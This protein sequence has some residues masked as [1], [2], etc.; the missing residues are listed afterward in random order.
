MQPITDDDVADARRGLPRGFHAIYEGLAPVVLG[1]LTGRRVEDPE[2][3]TQEVLLTLFRRLPEFVGGSEELRAFAFTIAHARVVDHIRRATRSGEQVPY[4][5]GQDPRR[6]ASAEAEVLDAF[7]HSAVAG[8]VA[9]LPDAQRDVL[10]LRIVGDLSLEQVS[11][12]MSR[13]VGATKQLQHRALAALRTQ[14]TRDGE[15]V[16]R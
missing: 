7:E 16:E 4:D 10:L 3:V 15:E 2:A 9:A 12:I 11:R 14:Y 5:P 13:S 6:A 8:A 1:Y